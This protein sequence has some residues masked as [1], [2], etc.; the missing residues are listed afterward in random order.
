M[1]GNRRTLRLG[2]SMWLQWPRI[3]RHAVLL[4]Q[5]LGGLDRYEAIQY[6]ETYLS[7]YDALRDE[8]VVRLH[9]RHEATRAL[10]AF[11]GRPP[12]PWATLVLLSPRTRNTTG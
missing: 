9:A 7:V 11:I 4:D 2:F 12:P 1:T 6:A 5:E 8:G 10:Y 3:S